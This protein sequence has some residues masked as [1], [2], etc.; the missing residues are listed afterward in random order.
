MAKLAAERFGAP[1]TWELSIANVDKP[2]LDF[3]EI[4][5][6]LDQLRGCDVLLSHAATFA[7]KSA[8]APGCTFVVGVDTLVRI[9]DPRYY[10]AGAT[11]RD[12]AIRTIADH[13]C[14]FFVFGRAAGDR[15]VTL[16]D[17]ELPPELASLCEAV[18]E[19]DFREDVSSTELRAND[20]E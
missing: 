20:E 2:P 12:A 18:A 10:G 11:A 19:T 1:V 15:F 16:N 14:R 13:G 9:A 4:G 17:V 5:D 8:L 3:V 7:Q 6:R